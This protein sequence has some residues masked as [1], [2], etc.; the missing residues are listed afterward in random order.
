[1]IRLWFKKRLRD[2]T[3]E[4][5]LELGREFLMVFGPSGSGKTTLLRLIAGLEKPDDGY[6]EVDGEVWFDHKKV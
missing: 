2:F 5:E 6:L 3:L 4:V 1:M